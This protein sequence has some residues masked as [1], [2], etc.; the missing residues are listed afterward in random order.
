M[1][2]FRRCAHLRITRINKYV[3]LQHNY[4]L[5]AIDTRSSWRKNQCE[6]SRLACYRLDFIELKIQC[7]FYISLLISQARFLARESR[8][9]DHYTGTNFPRFGSENIEKLLSDIRL[10]KANERN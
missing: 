2:N 6:F 9:F 8:Y 4:A 10:P 5:C 7:T 1:L 3:Q